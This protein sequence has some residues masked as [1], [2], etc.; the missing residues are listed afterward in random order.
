MCD[1]P[2]AWEETNTVL[3]QSKNQNYLPTSRRL[4]ASDTNSVRVVF[5][6]HKKEHFLAEAEGIF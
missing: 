4:R 1:I 2:S 5:S 3:Q 6:L